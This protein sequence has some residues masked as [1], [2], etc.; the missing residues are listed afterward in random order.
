[1]IVEMPIS[2]PAPR[3]SLPSMI[4]IRDK[5]NGREIISLR[6][7]TLEGA[8]L[9]KMRLRYAD[10]SNQNMHL[11]NLNGAALWGADLRGAD[12]RGSDMR[13]TNLRKANLKGAKLHGA[14]L[15][16]A[17]YDMDTVWPDDFDLSWEA[18]VLA[19]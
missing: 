13:N 15:T 8:D 9:S 14:N 5:E 17:L 1:M 16:N 2:A 3:P 12:L 7:S 19:E 10:L 18:I 11:A 4:V 6:A